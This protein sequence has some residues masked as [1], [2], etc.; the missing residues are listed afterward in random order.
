M[1]H[2]SIVEVDD[3][4]KNTVKSQEWRHGATNTYT[5]GPKKEKGVSNLAHSAARI[6]FS[7]T[8]FTPKKVRT[9]VS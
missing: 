4:V 7:K 3:V 8:S 6:A 9:L 1:G 2:H 5:P